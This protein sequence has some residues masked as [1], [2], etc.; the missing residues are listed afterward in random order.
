MIRLV[1]LQPLPAAV[2]LKGNDNEDTGI[3]DS[4]SEKLQP[5]TKVDSISTAEMDQL[6]SRVAY[7]ESIVKMK[8][9]SLAQLEGRME[10]LKSERDSY[11]E[12]MM[13]VN[14]EISAPISMT[15]LS[16]IRS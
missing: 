10:E 4:D 14:I 2:E 3:D 15:A 16:L 9:D 5:A 1:P 6:R 12:A 13:K 11:R 8:T 7:L